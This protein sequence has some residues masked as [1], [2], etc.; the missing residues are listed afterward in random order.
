METSDSIS[1]QG[2]FY[3]CRLVKLHRKIYTASLNLAYFT[4]KMW[5]FKNNR[6]FW[7]SEQLHPND[8]KDFSFDN[9]KDI[10]IK[11]FYR[12]A[13]YGAR[14]YILKDSPERRPQARTNYKR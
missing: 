11:Q 3:C 4:T 5:E 8:Y 14:T 1:I 2:N 12:N 6:M 13:Y 10:D 7:L 9:I